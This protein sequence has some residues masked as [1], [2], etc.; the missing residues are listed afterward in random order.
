MS[1]FARELVASHKVKDASGKEYD[2]NSETSLAQCEF[3][4]ELIRRIDARVCLEIGLAFGV[5]SLFICDALR[6]KPGSKLISIDP[7]QISGYLGIGLQHLESA[8]CRDQ[9]EFHERFSHQ[10]LPELLAAGVKLD[11]A[12]VDSTKLFDVLLVDVYY[13]SRMLRVGGILVLDDCVYP[14]VG[15]LARFISKWPHFRVVGAHGE[16]PL[17]WPRRAAAALAKRV[18][19][20]ERLFAESVVNLG[21]SLGINGRCVA[22]EKLGEDERSWQWHA[23]F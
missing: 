10:V 14:S 11:F 21:S 23:E 22:F 7:F 19:R 17:G 1:R 12:Y 2:L 4:V 8:G 16:I 18:P 6:G 9:V 13:L 5:S 20:G 15:K 3:L